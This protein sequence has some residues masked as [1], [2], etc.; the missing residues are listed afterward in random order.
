MRDAARIL[1]MT[2]ADAVTVLRFDRDSG[3]ARRV[4]SSMPEV[5]AAEGHK[6]LTG[7]AWEFAADHLTPAL[8]SRGR[9]ALRAHFA[10]HQVI[11]DHGIALIVNLPLLAEGVCLGAVNCLYR[12]VDVMAD[13][14]A[15]IP[16]ASAWYFPP[17]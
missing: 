8:I 13:F 15:M 14:D 3:V 2:G 1:A 12:T 10:D 5:F 9:A 16:A 6:P 4:W 11:E 17:S 7:A